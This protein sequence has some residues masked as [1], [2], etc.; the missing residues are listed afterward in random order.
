MERPNGTRWLIRS[1][2]ILFVEITQPS[3]LCISMAGVMR[4]REGR[5]RSASLFSHACACEEA[6]ERRVFLGGREPP[7]AFFGRGNEN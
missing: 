5:R 2:S 6:I 1:D 4:R 3:N 7:L